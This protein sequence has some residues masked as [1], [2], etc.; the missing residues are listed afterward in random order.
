[1]DGTTGSAAEET[2]NLPAFGGLADELALRI[3]GE[4]L[5]RVFCLWQV[6]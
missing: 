6:M 4:D 2:A 3:H 5:G 1:M